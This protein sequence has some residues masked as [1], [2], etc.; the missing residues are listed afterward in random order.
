MIIV[1]KPENIA[2]TDR[3]RLVKEYF[4]SHYYI[5]NISKRD[6]D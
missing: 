5:S 2:N 3:Y 4:F 1:L 6:D